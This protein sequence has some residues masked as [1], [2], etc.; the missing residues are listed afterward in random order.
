[1]RVVIVGAGPAG[2]F[3]ALELANHFDVTIIEEKNFVGGS[4]LHSDGKLNFHPQIGGN[5]YEF[6]ENEEAFDLLNYLE[7]IFERYGVEQNNENE[8]DKLKQLEQISLIN[9]LKFIPIRQNHIGSDYLPSVMEKFKK[10]L[11]SK[12]VEFKL[13]TKVLNIE[14]KNKKILIKTNKSVEETDYVLLCP[15]RLGHIWLTN[16]CKKLGLEMQF[17][18]VDVGVRVEVSNEILKE[19]VVDYK[20]WDP[21]FH[22][23]TP[24]YDDFVRTFCVCPFGFVVKEFYERD[25]FG[26]NGHSMRDKKSYNSNFGFLVRVNLTEPFENTLE[27]G[28]NIAQQANTLGGGKPIIQRLGDLKKHRRSTW[29]RIEKSHVEPTLKNVTPGDISMAYPFRIITNLVEGLDILGKVVPGVNDDSTLLYAPE[30]KFYAM[31]IKTNKNMQTKTPN[32]FVAGDGAGISRG[33]VGAAATGIIAAR[34][35]LHNG[36]IGTAHNHNQHHLMK[37]IAY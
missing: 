29:E 25:V 23:R 2:L 13:N 30:I 27:Y 32:I 26:V 5:L 9:G 8:I 4:G 14:I 3:A 33:I 20:C 31:R 16:L 21:K 15:G 24:S 1:M 11:E 12:G 22:I 10:D 18:P 19:I 6:L 35:I 36:T 17:N 7:K 34:G 37:T 28:R